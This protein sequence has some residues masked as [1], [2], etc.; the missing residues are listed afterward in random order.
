MSEKSESHLNTEIKRKDVTYATLVE[1]FADI[2]ISSK[3][4]DAVNELSEGS[5]SSVLT[6]MSKFNWRNGFTVG[7]TVG[8][9][10][11]LLPFLFVQNIYDLARCYQT[12]KC[13]RSA[14]LY[15]SQDFPSWWWWDWT[16]SLVTSDDTLAQWLMSI[17]TIAAVFLVWRTLVVTR[18]T[19]LATQRMASDA[20]DIGNRQTRAYCGV[21]S[22]EAVPV[23]HPDDTKSKPLFAKVIIKNF[24][25]SPGH[26]CSGRASL[27]TYS[28]ASKKLRK[29][30]RMPIRSR[31][32]LNPGATFIFMVP[33]RIPNSAVLSDEQIVITGHWKYFD[34]FGE[35]RI[36]HF[37]YYFEVE[38]DGLIPAMRGNY[39]T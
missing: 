28:K 2:G 13:E 21:E 27:V 36:S 26:K 10:A 18:R 23:S 25:Q 17:L 24:G 4:V 11:V 9:A 39:S 29:F 3:K 6:G 30:E 12:Q 14:A 32:P 1:S 22:I 34:C 5:F 20:R 31:A 8:G 16:G 38:A 37:R 33:L 15:E 35:R 19:L 7:L